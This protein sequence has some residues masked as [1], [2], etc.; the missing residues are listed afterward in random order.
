[1]LTSRGCGDPCGLLG[2]SSNSP[3][4]AALPNRTF[5]GFF[6]LPPSAAFR[7]RPITR[8]VPGL[9]DPARN[10]R[11]VAEGEAGKLPC[12]L[13]LSSR[14]RGSLN[15]INALWLS[16]ALWVTAQTNAARS[17]SGRRG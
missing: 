9:P 17:R 4:E 15:H 16:L 10:R 1:R 12:S 6:L 2:S 5:F 11:P 3:V 7:E 13:R 8:T 14:N